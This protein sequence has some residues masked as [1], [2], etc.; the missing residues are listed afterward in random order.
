[1]AVLVTAIHAF[2]A[3]PQDVD[4]SRGFCETA[5]GSRNFVPARARI[6]SGH[7]GELGPI[8]GAKL[9]T[10]ARGEQKRF[11]ERLD[12]EQRTIY[13]TSMLINRSIK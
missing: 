7:D 3:S 12:V 4:A 2:L 10:L 5:G 9:A 11:R 13:L 8:V 1:M 6:K